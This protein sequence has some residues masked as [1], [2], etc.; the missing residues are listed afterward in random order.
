MQSRQDENAPPRS[1]LITGAGGYIGTQLVAALACEPRPIARVIATDIRAPA[2]TIAGIEYLDLDVRSAGLARVLKER[3]VEAIVHLASVVTPGP[4]L[5]RH[6]QYEIDVLGTK[7][8]L[9]CC[10]AARV[11]HLIVTSSGAAYGYHA[12]NPQPLDEHDDLRGNEAFAYSDHKRQVEALLARYRREHPELRQLVLRLCTVLGRAVSNQ[13]VSLFEKPVVLGV[14]GAQAPFVFVSDTDVVACLREGLCRRKQGV[15]NVAGD[16]TMTTAEIAARAGKLHVAVPPGLLRFAL[17]V[18]H[19]L[20]LS[21]YGPE[22]VDFLRY[23]PVLSN[24]KLKREF[25]FMPTRTSQEAFDDYWKS[26]AHG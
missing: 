11:S 14:R 8:V 1:V 19:P 23:R 24:A 18:L 9:E 6:A 2:Q 13:I 20:G 21:R 16:G 22:Q 4:G 10:V 7:N 15:Y 5:S 3:C 25:G 26:R 17:G 12:D